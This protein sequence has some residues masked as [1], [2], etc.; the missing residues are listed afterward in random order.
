MILLEIPFLLALCFRRGLEIIQPHPPRGQPTS[1]MVR[2]RKA[3][4]GDRVH[5]AI[6][7]EKTKDTITTRTAREFVIWSIGFSD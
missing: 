4:T 6:Q 3:E 2:V 5:S 1:D 7:Q